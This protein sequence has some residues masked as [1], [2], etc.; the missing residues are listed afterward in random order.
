M[1]CVFCPAQ[2]D[3]LFETK[4]EEAMRL[5]PAI[6]ATLILVAACGDPNENDNLCQDVVCNHGT[7]NPGTGQCECNAD[8]FDGPKGKC[9]LKLDL[10]E[11]LAYTSIGPNS[12]G[13]LVVK[14][15]KGA[16]AK[17]NGFFFSYSSG[18]VDRDSWLLLGAAS[19]TGLPSPSQPGKILDS[20][21]G[22][23]R[24]VV[25]KKGPF[26]SD[27]TLKQLTISRSLQVLFSGHRGTALAYDKVQNQFKSV[28]SLKFLATG[29]L[30]T[31]KGE[32]LYL[33][34]NKPTI[35]VTATHK[36]SGKVE[37][38]F[39]GT[40]DENDGSSYLLTFS[41]SGD[42]TPL[43]LTKQTGATHKFTSTLT[44]GTHKVT[45]TVKDPYG[46][47]DTKTIT[48]NVDLCKNVQC[49]AWETCRKLDGKCVGSD[50][51]SP[52]PCKNG[53][54]CSGT[55]GTA[56]C[57]CV[58]PWSG[59]LCETKDLCYK[60]NCN[61]HGTCDKTTGK[62]K[63]NAGYDPAKNCGDCSKDFGPKYPMCKPKPTITGLKVDCS[64]HSGWCTMNGTY[65]LIW[66]SANATSYT[67]S[68]KIISGC[69]KDPG[70][71]SPTSGTIKNSKTTISYTLGK[72]CGPATSEITITV[73]GAGGT[74]STKLKVQYN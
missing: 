68:A 47:T 32:T 9:S 45:A 46:D 48:I 61:G 52:N 67:S 15:Q 12:S 27:G 11:Y 72:D 6:L 74:A 41:A 62:C 54:T 57:T 7:C 18:M 5:L 20:A 39:T 55:T 63:C 29:T 8:Y 70:K 65:P 43:T 3:Q 26:N 50:P 49:K 42:G 59:K 36:G 2:C 58:K 66:N 30:A 24:F 1:I 51:C 60:V 25:D 38:D 31:T 28:E 44:G 40:K 35:N 69:S 56:K 71:V 17:Y 22:V 37:F 16:D 53:G 33:L 14:G 19:A 34:N 23:K 21:H 64:K 4:K 13:K 73:S 10:T